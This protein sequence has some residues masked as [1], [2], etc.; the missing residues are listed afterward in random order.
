MTD[1]VNNTLLSPDGIFLRVIC[2]PSHTRHLLVRMSILNIP[3]RLLVHP[4]GAAPHGL[5]AGYRNPVLPI[6]M[7]DSSSCR[8]SVV[9][10]A[11]PRLI[12]FSSGRSISHEKKTFDPSSRSPWLLEVP[13]T[14]SMRFFP[15]YP[16]YCEVFP[17]GMIPPGLN[18]S[19][20]PLNPVWPV[21]RNGKYDHYHHGDQQENDQPFFPVA[22][23][24]RRLRGP[25]CTN[26]ALLFE[27][28][29]VRTLRNPEALLHEYP[30]K[31]FNR[32][33]K[34]LP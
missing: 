7:I 33:R 31:D 3:R 22:C 4:G 1:D 21:H 17:C 9:N 16:G 15:S 14:T 25:P 24:F 26:M 20:N 29:Y 5:Q 34:L 13:G 11:G 10:R 23:I 18:K 30:R 19:G 8:E 32:A 12:A 2:L 28:F 27:Y 6:P